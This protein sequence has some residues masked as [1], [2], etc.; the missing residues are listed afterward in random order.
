MR[1]LLNAYY[2]PISENDK[3]KGISGFLNVRLSKKEYEEI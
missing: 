1:L 3:D 2:P